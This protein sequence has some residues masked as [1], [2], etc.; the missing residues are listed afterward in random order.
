M[1]QC[2]PS[3]KERFFLFFFFKTC[4]YTWGTLLCSSPGYKRQAKFSTCPQVNCKHNIS[5]DLRSRLRFAPYMLTHEFHETCHSVTF[6]CM[7]KDTK[8]CCD[9]TT[10]ESIHTKDESKRET[11]FAFIFGVNRLWHYG[12]TALFGV[13]FELTAL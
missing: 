13:S 9:T 3:K 8:R 11:A 12:V 1:F 5:S 7:E 10:P 2:F 4:K 6:Y